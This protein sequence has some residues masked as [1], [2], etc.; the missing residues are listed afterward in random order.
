MTSSGQVAVVNG[1][2]FQNINNDGYMRPWASTGS[3]VIGPHPSGSVSNVILKVKGIASQTGDLQQW[4]DSSANILAKID[5]SGIE[6]VQGLVVSSQPAQI[7][8]TVYG[9][10]AFNTAPASNT[11]WKIATLPISGNGTYD[12]IQ[13]DAIL[14]DS[15]YGSGKTRVN[16][17]MGNRGGFNCKYYMYGDTRTNSKII[18]YTESDGSVS[19]YAYAAASTYTTFSYNI[20]AGLQA[21]IYR[22]PVSTTTAPTGTL[23]FD[24]SSTTVSFRVSGTGSVQG[25]N[26]SY[27]NTGQFGDFYNSPGGTIAVINSGASNVGINIKAHGSQSVN[28]QQWMNSSNTVLAAI[29]ATG[30]LELNGKDVEIMNIMGAY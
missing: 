21:T 9:F 15:W 3:M 1:P 23:A 8:N 25:F 2:V 7:N 18:A 11:Y 17:L 29:T 19:V 26:G 4:Q 24:S 10:S 13:I 12:H 16:I 28:M 30:S 22:N 14:D 27:F 6:T 5:A 20:S